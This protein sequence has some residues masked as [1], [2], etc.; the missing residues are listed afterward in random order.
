MAWA[1]CLVQ[2]HLK[3]A[4]AG[5]LPSAAEPAST[6]AFAGLPLLGFLASAVLQGVLAEQSTLSCTGLKMR[7][8]I[9][10]GRS[11]S[12][13]CPRLNLSCRADAVCTNR[14]Y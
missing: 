2:Q 3:Q 11:T 14:Q 8:S 13:K 9:R 4:N 6:A 5:L 7:G 10:E 1:Y 12:L